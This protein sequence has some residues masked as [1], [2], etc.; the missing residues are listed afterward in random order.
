MFLL[1]DADWH[2]WTASSHDLGL[3]TEFSQVAKFYPPYKYSKLL[4]VQENGFVFL[5]G[6]PQEERN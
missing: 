5:E 4:G 6:G 2:L 1:S 3:M